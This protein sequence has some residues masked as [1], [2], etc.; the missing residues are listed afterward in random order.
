MDCHFTPRFSFTPLE[1]SGRCLLHYVYLTAT[2]TSYLTDQ[3]F[4]YKTH[5]VMSYDALL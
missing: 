2:V 4:T 1:F 3:D 5:E